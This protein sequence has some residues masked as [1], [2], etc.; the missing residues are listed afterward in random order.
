VQTTALQ[1]RT[2]F[3]YTLP[4]VAAVILCRR[5]ILQC[6]VQPFFIVVPDPLSDQ[7][8]RPRQVAQILLRERF[9]RA[10]VKPLQRPVRLGMV[11]AN[12]DVL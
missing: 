5:Q 6:S 12:P 7:R 11:R 9:A 8:A 1:F 2:A 10:A 3:T 4:R